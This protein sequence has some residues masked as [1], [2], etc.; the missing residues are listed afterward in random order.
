MFVDQVCNLDYVFESIIV[1]TIF[2][3]YLSRQSVLKGKGDV[4]WKQWDVASVKVK[5]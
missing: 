5:L 1:V 3:D 4:D 2:R